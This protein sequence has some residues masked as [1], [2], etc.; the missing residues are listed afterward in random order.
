MKSLIVVSLIAAAVFA[1]TQVFN[2]P[3]PKL[4][5]LPSKQPNPPKPAGPYPHALVD[6]NDFKNLVK[7]V[8]A[9]RAE[10]L[11]NLD[12][13]LEMSQEPNTIILDTRSDSR[14]ERLHLKGAKH[15]SFTDFT[16][17][18]LDA[19]IPDRKTRILI[20]C[21]NN[22]SGEQ[23]NFASKMFVP[24]TPAAT[25]VTRNAKPIMLALNIPTY[26]NLYGYGFREIYEL[27]E[28]VN[29]RDRRITLEGT[30]A[31]RSAPSRGGQSVS[32][33]TPPP[34]K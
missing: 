16:Q 9:H 34:I 24:A 4:D 13:F 33:Y 14:F 11:V 6:Y 22:F 10:R 28:L 15:L 1:G 31:V 21:N 23:R 32:K 29:V 25:Q 19:L 17:G 30:E 2:S 18:N 3:Q 12:K 7:V 8:E 5:P 26:I 20:Y 27:D